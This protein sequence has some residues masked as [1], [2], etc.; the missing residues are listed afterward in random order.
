MDLNKDGVVTADEIMQYMQ[1]QQKNQ[2]SETLENSLN[3][4][5]SNNIMGGLN[6]L[7]A[8]SAYNNTLT[9]ISGSAMTLNIAV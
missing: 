3:K 4:Y 7:N 9:S 2:L 6:T 5:S 1:N 8:A